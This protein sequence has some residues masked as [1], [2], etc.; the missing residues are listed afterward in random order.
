MNNM[1]VEDIVNILSRNTIDGEAVDKTLV[2]ASVKN[3]RTL[4]DI[5]LDIV[6]LKRFDVPIRELVR[7]MKVSATDIRA[8]YPHRYTYSIPY[9]II[10]SNNR[11][12]CKEAGY[13]GKAVSQETISDTPSVFDFNFLIMIDGKFIDTG[14]IVIRDAE[15]V[16][17]LDVSAGED[18]TLTDG[19][20]MEDYL[21][22]YEDNEIVTFM[23]VPNYT[24]RRAEFN[25]V[26]FNDVMKRKVHYNRFNTKSI[27]FD[28]DNTMFFMNTDTD[29]STKSGI[30]CT[31]DNENQYVV[32][33]DSVNVTSKRL[34]LSAITLQNIHEIKM[35]HKGESCWFQ[36]SED[37][38]LPVPVENIIPFT[39]DDSI[40]LRFEQKI[41][42]KLYYPNIYE[43]QNW[44]G[45][46]DL[47]LYIMY[48]DS[49]DAE[50]HNDLA[51]LKLLSGNLTERYE[52]SSLPD[53]VMDYEPQNVEWLSDS[54]SFSE[55]VYFPKKSLYNINALSQI[56]LRNPHFLIEYAY[57]KLKSSPK[58]YIN[59]AKLSL[60][61]RVRNDSYRECQETGEIVVFDE[62]MYLFS[63]R[64]KFIGSFGTDFRIFI[65][66][67][68]ICPLDYTLITTMD[69]YHFYIPCRFIKENS[70]MEIEKYTE[71]DFHREV[72]FGSTN[73][74]IS[75]EIPK[76]IKKILTHDISII[77][78]DRNTYLGGAEYKIVAYSDIMESEIELEP[79]GFSTIKGSFKII[80]TS[81]QYV[82]KK[83]L[84]NVFHRLTTRNISISDIN[85]PVRLSIPNNDYV[86]AD[87]L[88][89]YTGGQMLPTSAYRVFDNGQYLTNAE[90]V[91]FLD[92]D[93]N[94]D[95]YK[96]LTVDEIP[97]G[98]VCEFK[99]SEIDNEYGFVDTGNALSL[100]LDLKWY[101]IYVNGLKL[102]KS[103]V[104]I[105]TSNK[106][107]IKGI[108]S[109]KN[110]Y[111]YARGDV[112]NEFD[113]L[114]EEAIENKLFH[115]IDDIY[116]ELLKDRDVIEDTMDD[117]TSDLLKNLIDHFEFVNDILEYTFINANEQQ[118]TEEIRTLYP[119]LI[120]ENGILWL[121]SNNYDV[122]WVTMINSNVRSNYMKRDQYR[123]G[124]SPLYIGAHED[125]KAGEYMCD[126]V[127]G[128]PGMKN[129]DGSVIPTGELDRLNVH[130]SRLQDSLG[131]NCLLGLDIYHVQFDE[132]TTAKDVVF[133]E[134]V[135]DEEISINDTV[136]KAVL[137]IDL[138]V[139]K[140]GYQ[141]VLVSSDYIPRVEIQYTVV[142]HERRT[143][144]I[145][146][147]DLQETILDVSGSGITI[148]SVTVK[149]E[150]DDANEEV[151]VKCILHS[152]L[153]AI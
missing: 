141:D 135:L 13:Y 88:R 128:A 120:D 9:S 41:S 62:P 4:Y 106:F 108:D 8:H 68:F 130:K 115:A 114:H 82:G 126:P 151:Q 127:T 50:Y 91:L 136:T 90:F 146:Y 145:P 150:S 142:N 49:N 17:I 85:S 52:N 87:R 144:V 78:L 123:Y 59:M 15:T 81:E 43:I 100:P 95:K 16:F 94:P 61:E 103:N 101:D 125:A 27:Q 80:L 30:L 48:N 102:N 11:K 70:I 116:N 98:Q 12:A 25:L 36:L 6:G 35:I 152:I 89:V 149:P 119:E 99:L 117:I 63:M 93:A 64:K 32:F 1:T 29:K 18:T 79:K 33:P 84:V 58:Y 22:Y 20:P 113:I 109:L 51:I 140:R 10:S 122:S 45:S 147:N 76:S 124:W 56:V 138:Q 96:T 139:L 74:P 54:K 71:Y 37:Y 153:L 53:I 42:L 112:Y 44:D 5:Q 2:S 69:F 19:I 21:K 28:K 7:L 143:V 23:V 83:L 26:T 75:I 31:V 14:E 134:N 38:K 77:D 66:N 148:H 110:L 97:N 104:D 46:T 118:I 121:E 133:N 86:T 129:K 24:F 47:A 3:F 67:R 55:S 72:T 92:V 34:C 57:L 65:D 107:F 111:I 40:G 60:P 73:S 131:N 132:N 105:I 137:S 39:K